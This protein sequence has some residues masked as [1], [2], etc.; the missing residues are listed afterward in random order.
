VVIAMALAG[1]LVGRDSARTYVFREIAEMVGPD[2]AATIASL[3]SRVAWTQHGLAAGLAGVLVL[4]V[5]GTRVFV[6]IQMDLDDI[7]DVPARHRRGLLH[8]FRRRVFAVG[9]MLCAGLLIIASLAMT[10][11]VSALG[12]H[13]AGSSHGPWLY[14][15]IE[16]AVSLAAVA[17]A[18]AFLY[19]ELPST[20]VAWR[21]VWGAAVIASV[22]FTAPKW[23]VGVYIGHHGFTSAHGA[24]AAF[25]ALMVW[26]YYSAQ[27]F[28]LGA[29]FSKAYSRRRGGRGRIE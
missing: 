2:S 29:E 21:D 17:A 4:V 27:V 16:G 15:V 28:L 22:L 5:A 26:I 24:A 1:A 13:W 23:F 3:V 6:E 11:L 20:A 19:K 9:L 8:S 18:F 14:R 25:V 12:L 7:W 10:M